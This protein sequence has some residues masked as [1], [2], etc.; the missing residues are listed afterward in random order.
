MSENL[1]PTK[2][3]L[4]APWWLEMH[5]YTPI[6]LVVKGDFNG[7]LKVGFWKW[8]SML[9]SG[10]PT[11]LFSEYIVT[12]PAFSLGNS[13]LPVSCLM[14]ADLSSGTSGFVSVLFGYSPPSVALSISS[15]VSYAHIQNRSKTEK[16]PFDLSLFPPLKF[17]LAS[18]L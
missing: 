14:R 17:F 5:F 9:W 2:G 18:V 1:W 3:L 11:L 15:P 16:G 6:M 8:Q 10:L 12:E 7:F 4:S 13:V